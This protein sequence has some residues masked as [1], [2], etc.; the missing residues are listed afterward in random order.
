MPALLT[1]L[2]AILIGA[3]AAWIT[4]DSIA[5]VGAY[6]DEHAT[7]ETSCIYGSDD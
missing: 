4:L 5:D 2:T 7:D 1:A 6:C 3:A